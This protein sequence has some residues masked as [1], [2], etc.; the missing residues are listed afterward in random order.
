MLYTAKV[1]DLKKIKRDMK[2]YY[3]IPNHGNDEVT[4]DE[5]DINHYKNAIITWKGFTLNY[6][7]KL[8][9]VEAIEWMQRVSIEAVSEDVVLVDEASDIEYSYRKLLAERIKNMFI[10]H[11]NLKYMGEL[12]NY[13]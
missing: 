13:S 9:R 6:S 8:M 5:S 2:I 10:G 11:L 3:L 12:I 4:P 1:S 7:E